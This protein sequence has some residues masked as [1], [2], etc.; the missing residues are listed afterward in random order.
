MHIRSATP[1][2]FIARLGLGGKLAAFGAGI[3]IATTAVAYASIPDSS[4]VIHACYGNSGALKVIDPSAGGACGHSETAISWSQTAPAG[5][6]GPAGDP[7]PQ[8]PAGPA[9]P[10]GPATAP[11]V[12]QA[13]LP[14][15]VIIN[16]PGPHTILSLT[17]P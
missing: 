9:G 14:A 17:L 5:P 16:T 2:D 3:V 13:F 8:G 4:G 12:Q 7:G 11:R 10:P 6:Q 15:A 1:L